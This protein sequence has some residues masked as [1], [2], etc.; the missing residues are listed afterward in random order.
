MF[1]VLAQNIVGFV[2]GVY[3]DEPSSLHMHCLPISILR[4]LF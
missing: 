4:K 3:S 2:A 1:D